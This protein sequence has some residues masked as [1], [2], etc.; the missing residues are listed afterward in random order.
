MMSS[1]A[2]SDIST[3]KSLYTG[4]LSR[5]GDRC[6]LIMGEDRLTYRELLQQSTRAGNGLLDLGVRPGTPVAIAMANCLEFAV[7]DQGVIQA[8][9]IKVPLN[10]MLSDDEVLY[11]LADAGARVAIVDE[12]RV[13]LLEAKRSQLPDLETV[14]VVG[15]NTPYPTG[16]LPWQGFLADAHP[17]YTQV[18]IT[19]DHLAFIGYT[20]G[21]TGKP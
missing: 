13:P 16:M 1:S 18:D 2:L 21:T 12:R 5:F 20:G 17:E 10:E 15:D 6:A 11:I 14:I 9:A 8:G 3:L 7:A 4:A 19:P